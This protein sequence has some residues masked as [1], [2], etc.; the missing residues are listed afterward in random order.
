[1]TIDTSSMTDMMNTM[2]ALLI[3]LMPLMIYISVFK[4]FPKLLGGFKF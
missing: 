2:I 4:L 3:G 1:M